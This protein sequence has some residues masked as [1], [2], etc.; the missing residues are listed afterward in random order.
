MNNQIYNIFVLLF[1]ITGI[2]GG[3]F[4]YIIFLEFITNDYDGEFS[5]FPKWAKLT[6]LINIFLTVISGI[7]III[8][9]K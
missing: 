7:I 3:L 2:L 1:P 5:P 4:H 6:F 8:F 9:Y